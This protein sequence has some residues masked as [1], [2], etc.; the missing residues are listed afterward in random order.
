MMSDEHQ[1]GF[2]FVEQPTEYLAPSPACL[3]FRAASAQFHTRGN[4]GFFHSNG[5]IIAL[6]VFG[7]KLAVADGIL[8][9]QT[10][11]DIDDGHVCRVDFFRVQNKMQQAHGVPAA[12]DRD[13]YLFTR[14]IFFDKRDCVFHLYSITLKPCAV[15]KNSVRLRNCDIYGQ[16]SA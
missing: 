5:D 14:R 16:N 8:S 4:V 13:G 1:L 9:A 6:A 15:K 10:V 12:A 11:F 7:N 2:F 3:V